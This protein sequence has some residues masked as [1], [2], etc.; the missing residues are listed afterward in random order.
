[1]AWR[2]SGTAPDEIE[3]VA[4]A[5]LVSVFEP[6]PKAWSGWFDGDSISM[7]SAPIEFLQDGEIVFTTLENFHVDYFDY[8]SD[9]GNSLVYVKVPQAAE[10]SVLID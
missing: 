8:F 4:V 10:V 9:G 5:Q 3:R 2:L 7:L 1:M 6:E